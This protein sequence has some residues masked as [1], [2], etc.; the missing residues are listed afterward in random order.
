L[1]AHCRSRADRRQ[2]GSYPSGLLWAI[3]SIGVTS[4]LHSLTPVGQ[5]SMS[6]NA[7][8]EKAGRSQV[9]CFVFFVEHGF[10]SPPSRHCRHPS[11]RTLNERFFRSV[12]VGRSRFSRCCHLIG[13]LRFHPKIEAGPGV[14][15]SHRNS[16]LGFCFSFRRTFLTYAAAGIAL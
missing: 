8:H 4:L 16:A 2:I 13:D 7:F 6:V 11:I 5:F 10:F 15:R 12:Q 3:V 14:R 1:S 9:S